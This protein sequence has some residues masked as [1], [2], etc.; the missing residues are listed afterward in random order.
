MVF[1]FA[2]RGYLVKG[3]RNHNKPIMCSYKLVEASFNFWGLQTKA[4]EYIQRTVREVL[5]LGHRQAFT[6]IDEWYNMTMNDVRAF[7]AKIYK[8]VNEKMNPIINNSNSSIS[9]GI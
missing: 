1:L 7:E 3:W 6:W 4:E 9:K 2:D 8:R 5:L